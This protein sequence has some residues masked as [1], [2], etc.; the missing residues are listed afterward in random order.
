MFG[1]CFRFDNI[2]ERAPEQMWPAA[3]HPRILDALGRIV[4]PVAQIDN[5]TIAAF[6]LSLVFWF[7]ARIAAE[8]V[9][10]IKQKRLRRV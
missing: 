8:N 4:G 5:F 1:V 9:M 2:L 3:S 10:S 6:V 7:K